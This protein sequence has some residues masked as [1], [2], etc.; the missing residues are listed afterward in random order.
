MPGYTEIKQD[1]IA[2]LN[3]IKPIIQTIDELRINHTV[4][5]EEKAKEIVNFQLQQSPEIIALMLEAKARKR[6]K[7][8]L[9]QGIENVE[10]NPFMLCEADDYEKFIDYLTGLPKDQ[11]FHYDIIFRPGDIHSTGLQ[12]DYDGNN[13][14]RIFYIETGANVNSIEREEID[15]ILDA[16]LH[17]YTEGK[18]QKAGYG[19]SIFS[20]QHL[21]KMSDNQR[22]GVELLKADDNQLVDLSPVFLKHIQNFEL[23]DKVK[24]AHLG[25]EFFIDKRHRKTFEQHL[26]DYTITVEAANKLGVPQT[27][28]MNTSILY[29]TEKYLKEALKTLEEI[30]ER[31]GEEALEQV[32]DNRNGRNIIRSVYQKMH[33][34]KEQFE[35]VNGLYNEDKIRLALEYGIS[36]DSLKKAH[37]FISQNI[38]KCVYELIKRE[39]EKNPEVPKERVAQ[40]EFNKIKSLSTKEQ[41]FAVVLY[42]LDKNKVENSRFFNDEDL[43]GN[44]LSYIH[45]WYIKLG[46]EGAK[47]AF[48]T[49]NSLEKHNKTADT[50]NMIKQM[51]D[52]DANAMLG[53]S[54]ALNNLA[55]VNLWINAGV[56]VNIP[57]ISG[58]T[59]LSQALNN[60]NDSLIARVIVAGAD[61]TQDDI[62]LYP[63]HFTKNK[64]LNYLRV[65]ILD[66]NQ[67]A[68]SKILQINPEIL[69]ERV[70]GMSLS[71]Y[72]IKKKQAS[73]L[74]Y[75]SP[76]KFIRASN[77][78]SFVD[79][80]MSERSGNE[81]IHHR[82]I[83]SK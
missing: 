35:K 77:E 58:K 61:I 31:G 54:I 66:K 55:A 63:Q 41:F 76:I 36:K 23:A 72:F 82:A 5:I 3:K 28:K 34:S 44:T 70:E 51:Q 49:L 7:K 12:I 71:A 33:L 69:N 52:S 68:A 48:E 37:C 81:L 25:E 13:K 27:K 83:K 2:G 62:D 40:I 46:R 16:E 10:Y 17:S 24:E 60:G 32:L 64:L 57:G 53:Y 30:H 47:A 56:D 42:G 59:I 9:E 14:M 1:L 11:P 38:S 21:N 65:A 22:E 8:L 26:E 19:C 79:S 73:L 4:A 39:C 43:S 50:I 18:V 15:K 74:K 29:K 20:K 45:S 80:L 78:E 6:N 75:L 67:E